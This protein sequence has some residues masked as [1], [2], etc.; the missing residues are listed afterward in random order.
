MEWQT[1]K[2]QLLVALGKLEAW[3][4]TLTQ[5]TDDAKRMVEKASDNF[6]MQPGSHPIGLS[7]FEMAMRDIDSPLREILA[8]QQAIHQRYRENL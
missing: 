4:A 5:A 7:E 8:I 2:A 6:I 1:E 3:S